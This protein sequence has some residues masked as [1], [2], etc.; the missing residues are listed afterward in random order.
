MRL[1]AWR[2][3]SAVEF[4]EARLALANRGYIVEP[5]DILTH[6]NIMNEADVPRGLGLYIS[7]SPHADQWQWLIG[8]VITFLSSRENLGAPLVLL[9]PDTGFGGK[10]SILSKISRESAT[11]RPFEVVLMKPRADNTRQ[12]NSRPRN[13]LSARENQVCQLLRRG[14]TLQQVGVELHI[15]TSTVASYKYR[16]M[17]KLGFNSNVQFFHYLASEF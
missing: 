14:L 4:D 17:Q 11:T 13:K 8:L 7:P 2:P 9:L 16:I 1:A 6:P 3:M 5:A 12:L 10:E 15:T